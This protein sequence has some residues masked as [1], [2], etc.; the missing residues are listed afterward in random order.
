MAGAADP[1]EALGDRLGGSDL[2]H[3]IDIPDVDAELEGRRRNGGLELA[4]FQ[5]LLDVQA[6]DLRKG[7]V[8][9]LEVLDATLLQA[10]GDMLRPA[11]RVR[12]DE[13][14]PM[15]VDQ[16]AQ[17]VV[18]PRVRDLHRDGRDVPD[19]TQDRE[20]EGLAGVDLDDVHVADLAIR[21]T[22]EELRLLLDWRDRGA[23]PD[24]DEVL[25][26]LLAQTLEADRQKGSALRRA[27]LVNLVEDDPLD[28]RKVLAELRGAKDDCDALR[29]RDEDMRRPSDLP[30]SFLGRRVPG[31][32]AHADLRLRFPLLLRQGRALLQG[33]LEVSV[34]VVREGL[35]RRDIEAIDPVLQFAAKLFGVQLV[36]DREEGREGLPAPR[37][38]RYE[39]ALPLVDEGDG[40]G[41]RLREVLELRL[42]PVPDEG[43]HEP[44]DLV[45]RG[46]VADLM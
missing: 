24:A 22:G 16:V 15:L 45:F 8:V 12:E 21:E 34:D 37:G 19:R 30:L 46:S 42:E 29:R 32:H 28:V 10:E 33:L 44:E 9:G 1:L 20:I 31:P 6:R 38:R 43:L 3:E 4:F 40:V 39:D 18:H 13:G 36:D 5:L 41:L 26:R 7:A 23:Q 35:Q 2:D 25:T 14:R 11:P 17:E 27:D